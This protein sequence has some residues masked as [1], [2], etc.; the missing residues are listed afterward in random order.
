MEWNV[1][2]QSFNRNEITTFNIFDH[3]IYV[4]DMEEILNE[5]ATIEEFSDRMNTITF[6]YFG[7]K[8]E[9]ELAL[10]D[11][12]TEEISRKIDVYQQL[13]LNWD[14]YI[15]YIWDNKEEI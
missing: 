2:L 8:C 9:Y 11:W 3:H 7:Y 1:Y 5:A 4:K 13:R 10:K 6:Y 14:R 12:I 15:Q